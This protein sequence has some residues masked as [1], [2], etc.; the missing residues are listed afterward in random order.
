MVPVKRSSIPLVP[1]RGGLLAALM[2]CGSACDTAQAD[3]EAP[4]SNAPDK[5]PRALVDDEGSTN[6]KAPLEVKSSTFEAGEAI[7]KKHTCD[8]DDVSPPLSWTGAPA[9]TRSLAL[10]AEDPD[11]PS[12]TFVHWLVHGLGPG[13]RGLE[14]NA[15]KKGLP[16]NAHQGRNDFGQLAWR[17]PC[18]PKGP[19]HRYVFRVFAL[20]APISLPTGAERS[21]LDSAMEGHIIGQGELMGR[22]ERAR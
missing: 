3:R 4:P 6:D 5:Q 1:W 14:A 15:S 7:P 10:V 19:A 18:P 9:E 21:A 11:A 20:D 13:V 2:L 22:Y 12:G 16:G 8:G 17:G